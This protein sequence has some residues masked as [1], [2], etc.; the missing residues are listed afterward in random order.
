MRGELRVGPA[1]PKPLGPVA[2]L[3]WL[4][5]ITCVQAARITVSVHMDVRVGLC[6]QLPFVLRRNLL[7]AESVSL[8]DRP[9][10]HT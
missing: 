5:F 8:S 10:V 3:S 6:F 4:G 1:V 9:P 2:L 7:A